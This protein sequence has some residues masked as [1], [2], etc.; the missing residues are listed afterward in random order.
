MYSNIEHVKLTFSFNTQYH[1]DPPIIKINH[2][3]QTILHETKITQ[4]QE[5]VFDLYLPN[6]ICQ[7][8]QITVIRSNYNGVGQQ[9]LTLNKLYVDDVNLKKICYQ[10]RYYPIY[11][12]PWISEQRN[13]GKHWPEYLT[14]VTE[15]G[16]NGQWVLD[17][18]TPIYTWLLKNV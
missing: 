10:S 14:G 11:P 15:W 8:G 12:E 5:L 9:L 4:P 16:W 17:F 1:C 18:E 3:N 6:D 13:E 7:L 2:N